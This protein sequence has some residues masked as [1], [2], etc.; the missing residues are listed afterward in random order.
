MYCFLKKSVKSKE[1]K[2]CEG[3]GTLISVKSHHLNSYKCYFLKVA[4]SVLNNSKNHSA[5]P[6]VVSDDISRQIN[7]LIGRVDVSE[8]LVGGK[9]V[10][11][12][13]VEGRSIPESSLHESDDDEYRLMQRRGSSASQSRATSASD[14]EYTK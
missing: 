10:L 1:K 11:S 8:G 12:I 4:F 5:W 9:T 3:L 2:S 6:L 13:P 14:S 7:A